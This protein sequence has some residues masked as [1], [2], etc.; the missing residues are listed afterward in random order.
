LLI[1]F[2]HVFILCRLYIWP[3]IGFKNNLSCSRRSTRQILWLL[4]A[5]VFVD[6][7]SGFLQVSGFLGEWPMLSLLV[8]IL[9][10]IST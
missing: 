10:Q 5:M 6:G 4:D 2:C 3:R 7:R 8:F 1:F 9:F